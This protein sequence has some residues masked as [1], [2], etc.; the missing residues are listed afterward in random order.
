MLILYAD[1]SCVPNPGQATCAVVADRDGRQCFQ[2]TEPIGF[3][4]NNVAEW[5]GAIA[6]LTF[7]LSQSDTDIELRMDS[8]LVVEQFNGKWR[9]KDPGLKPLAEVAKLIARAI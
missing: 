6:A 9:V 2:Q 3:G 8:Q 7:A 1:G 5:R 4:T